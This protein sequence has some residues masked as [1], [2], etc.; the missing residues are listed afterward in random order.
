MQRN[1]HGDVSRV[2]Q[3]LSLDWDAIAGVVAAVAAL[4]MHFLHIIEADV[5][6][7]I[8]VVLLA[9]LFIRDLRRERVTEHMDQALA[10]TEATV[11]QLQTALRPADA[12]LIAPR[13]LRA[14]SERFARQAC[15]EMIWFHVCLLMFKP[16]VL[17]D[18][19]LRPAIE[20]PLVTAIHFVLDHSQQALWDEDVLPKLRACHGYEKVQAPCWRAIEE[21]VSLIVADTAQPGSTECLMSFWGEPFMARTTG[22]H[23]PRY[24]FHIQAHSELVAQLVALERSYRLGG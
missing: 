14:E 1:E 16:Q 3:F 15:G 23:V 19:L 13:Q 6:L 22:R 2:K 8:A 10:R 17:F 11:I 24:I 20:N 4:I 9:L 21:N 12:I 7:M 5:L 18:T